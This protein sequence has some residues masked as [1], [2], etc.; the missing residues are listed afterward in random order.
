GTG[1]RAG[2]LDGRCHR[3]PA[4]GTLAG[5]GAIGDVDLARGAG[6]AAES[7]PAVRSPVGAGLP[8][9]GGDAGAQAAAGDDAGAAR[10]AGAR[11]VLPRPVALSAA[12]GGRTGGGVPA[13]ERLPVGGVRDG[14]VHP[15]DLQGLGGV[16]AAV[17]VARARADHRA[18]AG[19][20]GCAGSRD[21]LAEGHADRAL[22]PRRQ[23]L[24]AAGYW[25]CRADG[26]AA[27][28]RR[29]HA[30]AVAG[31]GKRALSRSGDELWAGW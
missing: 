18:V 26:A 3:D 21:Q 11:T 20:L 10:A 31:D 25:T 24:D 22:A 17:D 28:G 19:G 6:S 15:G 5:A 4:V 8:A 27:A 16:G 30:A 13:A 14:P 7:E 12:S 29:G 1:A 23:A 9:R 2:Q